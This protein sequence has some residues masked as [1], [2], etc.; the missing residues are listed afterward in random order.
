VAAALPEVDL[1]PQK[2]L[3]GRV[4]E[5]VGELRV[6]VKALESARETIE[7]AHGDASHA[8]L[9]VRERLLPAMERVRL[10][11]DCLEE[12]VDDELWPLPKYRELLF[13]H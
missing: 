11:C 8:A 5:L 6:S 12:V 2:E 13:V 7:S 10:A 4:A 3:L 9:T 1:A